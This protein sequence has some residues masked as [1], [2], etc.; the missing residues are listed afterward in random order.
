MRVID[1]NY[2]TRPET[3][4]MVG[5][6]FGEWEVLAYAGRGRTRG[7]QARLLYLCRCSCGRLATV[8]GAALRRH[9]AVGTS[10]SC[11]RCGRQRA[12]AVQRNRSTPVGDGRTISEIAQATG[13]PLDTIYHRF[14]RG[15]PAERL[16]APIA[17]QYQRRRK[18]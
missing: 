5:R 12:A 6:R 17:K 14:I 9:K 2:P 13:I 8:I 10:R 16:A 7:G 11:V 4:P 18:Q 3:K 15:W 1:R